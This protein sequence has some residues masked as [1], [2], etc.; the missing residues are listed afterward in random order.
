LHLTEKAKQ[1]RIIN[2]IVT[3][4]I[5]FRQKLYISDSMNFC[6]YTFPKSRRISFN[7]TYLIQ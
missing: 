2:P 7:V 1:T 5:P 4:E 3:A 6:R